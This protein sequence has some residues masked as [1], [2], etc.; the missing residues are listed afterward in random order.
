[1]SGGRADSWL[2]FHLRYLSP[3]ARHHLIVDWFRRLGDGRRRRWYFVDV[4]LTTAER[5]DEGL[6]LAVQCPKGDRRSETIC[7]A[8]STE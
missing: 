4:R 2:I 7:T 6:E 3:A 8:S 1:V 5:I